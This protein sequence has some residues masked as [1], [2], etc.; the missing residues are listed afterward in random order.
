MESFNVKPAIAWRCPSRFLGLT[1]W[2]GSRYRVSVATTNE[3]AAYSVRLPPFLVGDV[4]RYTAARRKAEP[5]VTFSF[6]DG[7]R[8]LLG[9]G[10]EAELARGIVFYKFGPR[11]DDG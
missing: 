11:D 7:V 3:N 10:L 8:A 9:K 1:R 6:A 2:V 4:K 5:G